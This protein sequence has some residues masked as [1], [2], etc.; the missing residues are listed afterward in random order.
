MGGTEMKDAL[1]Y[2]YSTEIPE[3]YNRSLF[4]ITGNFFSPIL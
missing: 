4:L 3:G 2:T 1:E